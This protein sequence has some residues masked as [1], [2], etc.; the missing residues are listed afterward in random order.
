[1][2]MELG[3]T[4]RRTSATDGE[5]SWAQAYERRMRKFKSGSYFGCFDRPDNFDRLVSQ[6]G[7]F[8]TIAFLFRQS[9]NTFQE[10]LQH[11]ARTRRG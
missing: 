6:P 4:T 5:I 2:R 3:G 8:F 7:V 11:R 10:Q 9:R 1:M